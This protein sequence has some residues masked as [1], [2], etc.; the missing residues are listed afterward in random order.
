[1]DTLLVLTLSVVLNV[2]LLL[3]WLA[4]MKFGQEMKEKYRTRSAMMRLALEELYILGAK[5]VTYTENG[6]FVYVPKKGG[7]PS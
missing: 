4:N 2:V 1:M 7:P 6:E 3:L 5:T